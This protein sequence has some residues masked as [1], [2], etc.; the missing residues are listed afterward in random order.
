MTYASRRQF[1]GQGLMAG[2]AAVLA[3][4]PAWARPRRARW[5]WLADLKSGPGSFDI[6]GGP[7]RED[8]TVG[9]RYFLPR[10]F[11]PSSPILLVIPGAGRNAGDYRDAWIET[12]RRRSVLVA[13]L[14]YPR[15]DYDYAAYQMGGVVEELEVL[16]APRPGRDG[17]PRRGARVD[18]SDIIYDINPDRESWLFADFDRVFEVL[19]DATGSNRRRYDLFGHSAGAQVAHRSVLFRP[20][21]K[22]DRIVAANAGLYTLPSLNQPPLTGVAGAG[23]SRA[24]LAASFRARLTVMLGEEDTE[25][26]SGTMKLRTPSIDEQGRTRFAR[27]RYFFEA[28]REMARSMRVPFHWRLRTVPDV[29]HDHRRM[30]AAAGRYLYG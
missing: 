1:L 28:A 22:V 5:P 12:A 18:D 11:T 25:R 19:A 6:P 21:S 8:S 7:G 4:G 2:A 9:V 24:S 13:A 30:S 10:T 3:G 15:A 16:N 26:G 14:H 20:E 29:G 23:P 17:L 27:G